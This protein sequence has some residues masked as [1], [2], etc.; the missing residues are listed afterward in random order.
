MDL[1]GCYGLDLL[2]ALLVGSLLIVLWCLFYSIWC[3]T[4]SIGLWMDVC[5]CFVY[6][7]LWFIWLWWVCLA[8][9][10]VGLLVRF[11]CLL[12]CLLLVFVFWFWFGYCVLLGFALSCLFVV[13]W[14]D[15]YCWLYVFVLGCV[16]CVGCFMAGFDCG[17]CLLDC[18][19]CLFWYNSVV[20]IVVL[21]CMIFCVY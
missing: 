8:L 13:C 18:W 6:L 11:G 19:C 12:R 17:G 9:I 14:C 3:Y 20:W 15:M 16:D 21:C 4:A 10:V 7:V 1:N 5:C 2:V